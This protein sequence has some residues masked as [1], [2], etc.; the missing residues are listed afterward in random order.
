MG[1]LR[2][3]RRPAASWRREP[4]RAA[5]GVPEEYGATRVPVGAHWRARADAPHGRAAYPRHC[6]RPPLYGSPGLRWSRRLVRRGRQGPGGR[7]KGQGVKAQVKVEPNFATGGARG[8]DEC[9]LGAGC[10]ADSTALGGL[11]GGGAPF[12][13]P[14]RPVSGSQ[15]TARTSE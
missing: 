7:W 8:G 10:R 1:V 3:E 12:H 11:P 6:R 2:I 5:R 14:D 13:P 15:T 9:A 4:A